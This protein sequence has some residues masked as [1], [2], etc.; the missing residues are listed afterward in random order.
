MY[1]ESVINALVRHSKPLLITMMQQYTR[2]WHL[3]L[4][5]QQCRLATKKISRFSCL[6]T[7]GTFGDALQ[8]KLK[9][10][11]FKRNSTCIIT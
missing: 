11:S 5:I 4:D 2:A 6:I 10:F 7:C 1:H 3:G 8:G 9:M